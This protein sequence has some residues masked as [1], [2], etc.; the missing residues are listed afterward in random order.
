MPFTQATERLLEVLEAAEEREV[1]ARRLRELMGDER[2]QRRQLVSL[3]DRSR[4]LAA[5]MEPEI[6]AVYEGLER[7]VDRARLRGL[8]R[9]LDELL[10]LLDPQPVRP[11]E[12]R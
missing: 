3:T 8:Y 9:S 11:Q 7:R 12:R 10:V 5:R 2:D 1:V 6:E 4:A